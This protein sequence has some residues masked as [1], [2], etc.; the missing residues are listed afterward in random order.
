M[1]PTIELLAFVVLSVVVAFIITGIYYIV[2]CLLIAENRADLYALMCASC[3]KGPIRN[4]AS[5]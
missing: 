3:Q 4:N 1:Y 5:T 2:M